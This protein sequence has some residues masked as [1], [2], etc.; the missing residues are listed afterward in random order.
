MDS[1]LCRSGERKREGEREREGVCERVLTN[2]YITNWV[3]CSP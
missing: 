3:T 1:G 2:D